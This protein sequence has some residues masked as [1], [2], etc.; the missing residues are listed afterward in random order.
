VTNLGGSAYYVDGRRGDRA[1][2]VKKGAVLYE[3]PAGLAGVGT[4]PY[5]GFGFKIYPFAGIM[6]GH[7]NLRVATMGPIEVLARLPGIWN[8][9]HRS[10]MILDFLVKKVRI[11][12]DKP[13]PY[14]HS[15]DG[16]GY[17][18]SVEF[19]VGPKPIKLV[20]YRGSIF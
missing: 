12:S 4:S 17:R 7:M 9:S 5:Y 11:E 6:P 8:G 15:G 19:E 16:Q 14:Q 2:E 20:D 1:I 13:L 3:G 18:T 10:N